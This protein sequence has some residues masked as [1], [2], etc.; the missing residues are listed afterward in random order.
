MQFKDLNLK[1]NLIEFIHF[2][3]LLFHSF[4]LFINPQLSLAKINYYY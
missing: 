3:Y 1:L 4:L 2:L